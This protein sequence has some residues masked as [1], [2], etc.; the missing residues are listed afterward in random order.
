MRTFLIVAL[1]LTALVVMA[2]GSEYRQEDE[3]YSG[4]D[5]PQDDGSSPTGEGENRKLLTN[6]REVSL[7]FCLFNGDPRNYKMFS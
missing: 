5:L 3:D 4:D 2:A 6:P 1:A 7:H